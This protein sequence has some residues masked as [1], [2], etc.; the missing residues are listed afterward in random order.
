MPARCGIDHC[1][2]RGEAIGAL[3]G[4]PVSANVGGL[5]GFPVGNDVGLLGRFGVDVGLARQEGDGFDNG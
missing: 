4:L 3:D 1:Q 5:E 2:Q